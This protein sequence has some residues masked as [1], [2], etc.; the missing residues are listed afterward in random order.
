VQGAADLLQRMGD[1]LLKARLENEQVIHVQNDGPDD[2]M[3]APGEPWW[4]LVLHPKD[5]ELVV[6]KTTQ[7]VFESN[8]DLAAELRAKGIT[9]LE[10]AGVQSDMCLGA[11]ASAAH[12]LGHSL[13]GL[14][15]LYVFLNSNR[16]SVPEPVPAGSWD[17]MSSLGREFFGWNKLLMGWLEPNQIRCLSNQAASSHFIE[18]IDTPGNKPKLVLINLEAGVTLAIEG[19]S[20]WTSGVLVYKIDTRINHGDGP[21]I[22]QKNLLSSGQQLTLDGWRIK[23]VAIDNSGFLIDVAK[24]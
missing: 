16:P 12:E 6:R 10:F 15:D 23:V 14:E 8:P 21:I 22:A 17:I 24:S 4:E 20:Q 7:N 5:N 13:F 1:R 2:E 3:D 19:R 9:E 11:S 18:A